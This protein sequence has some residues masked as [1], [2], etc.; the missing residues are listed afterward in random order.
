M[1]SSWR[2]SR[3]RLP[4]GIPLEQPVHSPRAARFESSSFGTRVVVSA[5][6]TGRFDD[7]RCPDLSNPVAWI[8]WPPVVGVG[9]R[10]GRS[11]VLGRNPTGQYVWLYMGLAV[12]TGNSYGRR[13]Q[14]RAME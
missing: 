4:Q 14:S 2:F 13:H 9:V 1:A 5:V 11:P 6:D 7:G 3:L 12:A 10:S 8:L